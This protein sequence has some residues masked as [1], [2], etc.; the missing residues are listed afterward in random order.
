MKDSLR[1][2]MVS[3][4]TFTTLGFFTL[5]S[6]VALGQNQ[7]GAI[8]S[9]VPEN[10][11]ANIQS[12]TGDSQAFNEIVQSITIEEIIVTAERT[13]GSIRSELERV[14]EKFFEDYSELNQID[15]YDIDCRATRWTS[16][17]IPEEFCWPVFF[18]QALANNVQDSM[19]GL[20]LY[21]P[22]A[23]IARNNKS[24]YEELRDNV[25]RVANENPEIKEDLLEYLRLEAA[26]NRKQRE[27]DEKPAFLFVFKMCR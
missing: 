13:R 23:F 18:E 6:S 11:W 27:C 20:S 10:S 12:E 25:A 2:Y 21:E 5:A 24:E 26:L 4:I 22:P 17:H 1:R 14:R 19:F 8:D 16:S 3:I 9:S 7:E 15:K